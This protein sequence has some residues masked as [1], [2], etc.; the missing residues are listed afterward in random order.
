MVK[1]TTPEIKL[2]YQTVFNC[3]IT[4]Q[5]STCKVQIRTYARTN[6]YVCVNL[7]PYTCTCIFIKRSFLS[8]FSPL[9]ICARSAIVLL[10]WTASWKRQKHSE[11]VYFINILAFLLPSLNGVNS[12]EE[13]KKFCFKTM[14]KDVKMW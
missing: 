8:G 1:L 4:A 9:S 13:V 2:L 10:L 3:I 5:F 6:Q 7:S 12:S 14:S 11:A